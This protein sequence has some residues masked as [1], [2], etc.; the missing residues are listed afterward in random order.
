MPGFDGTGPRG[1]GPMTGGG[2]GY[3]AVPLAR[4]AASSSPALFG[5]YGGRGRGYR[6]MY[7]AT[8][9]PG[10]MRFGAWPTVGSG[11]AAPLATAPPAEQ[12]L[13]LLRTQAEWMR[14]QLDAIN[15]R[16]SELERPD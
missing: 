8:G 3:C 12:E 11:A 16:I 14:R 4:G 5:C 2:R 7:Y 15:A 1:I 9:L 10:W 13:N 6:W